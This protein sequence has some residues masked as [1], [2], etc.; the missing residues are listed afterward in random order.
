MIQQLRRAHSVFLL[1]HGATLD[2]LYKRVDR[3]TFCSFLDRFWTKFIWNWDILLHGNPAVDIFNGIKLAAGGELG[4]GVGEEEWGSGE[5]EVLEGFVYRT[6][7]LVDLV[8]SRFGDA[9]AQAETPASSQRTPS[10][11][12]PLLEERPWLGSDVCPRPSDGVIFSGVGAIS[13][14]SVA[15]VSL[16]MEW[17]YRYGEAA[18]GVG[19]DPSSV[20]RRK[21]RKK[22][23]RTLAKPATP[24]PE[25]GVKSARTPSRSLSPGIPPPLVTATPQP[26]Q[27]PQ[28]KE[29]PRT[30]NE[31]AHAR[32][33]SA[34]TSSSLFGTETLMKYL[35]LGYGSSWG[36]SSSTPAPHPRVS[37]LR[38]DGSQAETGQNINPPVGV[39]EATSEGGASRYGRR[40]KPVDG[41][42][43]RFII[44]LRD[45]PENEESD[46]EDMEGSESGRD[47]G[48]AGSSNNRT[49]LR[50]LYVRMA[51]SAHG[52]D[53]EGKG[54]FE[55]LSM[56]RANK[57]RTD[58]TAGIPPANECK[59]MQVVVYVVRW[60]M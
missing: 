31:S 12:D 3:S 8:V 33:Y 5:R 28:V 17:I 60:L 41:T 4:I 51:T 47:R 53:V 35:T 25:A 37:E 29:Q 44:G 13:R 42:L 2:D 59:T 56:H 49:M 20:R 45:D 40:S 34:D 21:P 16:W 58:H 46:D 24:H 10:Y 36:F 26:S 6:N 55:T 50:T 30:S 39:S 27:T 9:P 14:W 43:R 38:K 57:K 54:N 52:E 7:G 48:D 15:Q 32:S 23:D 19:E 18:Y 22:R 1:H 11:S